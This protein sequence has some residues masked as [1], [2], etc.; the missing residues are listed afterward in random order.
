MAVS[1][2]QLIQA[3]A[4]KVGPEVTLETKLEKGIWRITLTQ[5]N[6]TAMLELK[7]EFVED[8]FEKGEYQ[9]EMAFEARV[10]KALRDLQSKTKA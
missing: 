9:Q 3:V 5:E 6:K 1:K 8:F 10:N 2:E 7:R 4:Q